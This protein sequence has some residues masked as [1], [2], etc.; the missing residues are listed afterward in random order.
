MHNV[1]Y[2]VTCTHW[3]NHAWN[4]HR[5]VAQ[6]EHP[7]T[8]HAGLATCPPVLSLWTGNI[9]RK[10]DLT[11]PYIHTYIY[12]HTSSFACFSYPLIRQCKQSGWLAEQ[13]SGD[14]F[15]LLVCE[16][17]DIT[18]LALHQIPYHPR[19]LELSQSP[20][21]EPLHIHVVVPFLW[22]ICCNQNCRP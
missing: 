6:P 2:Y 11:N 3:N 20:G 19:S 16:F 12:I 7:Y 21:Y 14:I 22:K 9:P 15:L 10:S 8:E 17:T 4:T 5:L 1:D 18:A 13:S